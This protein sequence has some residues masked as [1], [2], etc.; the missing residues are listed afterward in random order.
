MLLKNQALKWG[1]GPE[2]SQIASFIY[3]GIKK[4]PS[5]KITHQPIKPADPQQSMPPKT[6]KSDQKTRVQ[7]G[8]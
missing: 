1:N 8:S 4:Q 2:K 5:E 6:E 3:D 7:Q